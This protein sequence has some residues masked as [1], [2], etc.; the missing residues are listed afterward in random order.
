VVAI[1]PG[2]QWADLA[3]AEALMATAA[4]AL[5]LP[6]DD[7]PSI[8]LAKAPVIRVREA[9]PQAVAAAIAAA[10]GIRA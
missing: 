5:V 3:H 10:L 7:A 9:T 6:A 1:I 8:A 2:C 4:K